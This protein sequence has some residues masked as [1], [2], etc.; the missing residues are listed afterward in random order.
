MMR[1]FTSTMVFGLAACAA[2]NLEDMPTR[3]DGAQFY[4]QNCV[5]C[6]GV[7]GKGDGPEAERQVLRLPDLTNI[8]GRNGGEFPQARV[9]SY[10]WGDP[11][12]DHLE[13]V[14]PSFG[15]RMA[16]DLVPVEIDGILTPTP[17]QLAGLYFYMESIQN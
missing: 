6:H 11:D 12:N 17:R 5:A 14:M 4:A 3:D 2:T 1:A 9:M 7:T 8:S 13:R 15:G 10:I 16:D